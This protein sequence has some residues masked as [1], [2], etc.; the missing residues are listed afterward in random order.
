MYITLSALCHG[1]TLEEI[2][3]AWE[4]AVSDMTLDQDH[5]PP[6]R[7]R[8]GPDHAGNLLELVY[9]ESAGDDHAHSITVIHAMR[10]RTSLNNYLR[11]L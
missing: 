7:L 1:L 5:D 2:E 6:K 10:L 4:L 8:V 11:R 3:H 9:L